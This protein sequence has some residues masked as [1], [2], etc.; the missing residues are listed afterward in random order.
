MAVLSSNVMSKKEKATMPLTVRLVAI[1]LVISLASTLTAVFLEGQEYDG[2]GFT[3]PLISG[4]N[5]IWALVVVWML[6]DLFRK[7]NIESSLLFIGIVIVVFTAWNFIDFGFSL[8]LMFY[9]VE[10]LMFVISYVL[11]RTQQSRKWFA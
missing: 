7:R 4:T 2:M 9:L 1:A 8:P 10:L 6:W 5:I 3:E 11:I